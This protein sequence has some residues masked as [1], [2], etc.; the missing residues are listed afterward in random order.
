MTYYATSEAAV[1]SSSMQVASQ[2]E[3]KVEDTKKLIYFSA[4]SA[5]LWP[6]RDVVSLRKYPTPRKN[7]M[8]A[9]NRAFQQVF[10]ST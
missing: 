6:Y 5:K 2:F 10:I 1:L 9:R 7:K 4:V 8:E 3:T